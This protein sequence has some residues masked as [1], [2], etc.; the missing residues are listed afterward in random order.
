MKFETLAVH[1]G[2]RVDPVTGAAPPR[3]LAAIQEWRQFTIR[4]WRNTPVT[5]LRPGRWRCSAA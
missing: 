1:S 4:D 2:N 3:F 5:R